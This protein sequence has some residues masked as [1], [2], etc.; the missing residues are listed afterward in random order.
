[1]GDN[2]L[3]VS[4]AS[5]WLSPINGTFLALFG[6]E[7]DLK[8]FLP[9]ESDQASSVT[10]FKSFQ[11]LIFGRAP[12]EPPPTLPPHKQCRDFC[13][14]YFR[15]MNCWLPILHKPT[16]VAMVRHTRTTLHWLGTL[17]R[18]LDRPYISRSELPDDY[19]GEGSAAH[20]N[21]SHP[22]PV[23]NS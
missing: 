17:T 10:S 9:D 11:E 16:F 1:M 7:L 5:E 22:F 6:M 18:Q 2:Y 15:F 21:S 12:Q 13:D 19:T 20:G 23:Y 14:W 3:G 4:S 8:D